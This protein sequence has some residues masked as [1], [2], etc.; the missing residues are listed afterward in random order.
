MSREAVIQILRP[1]RYTFVTYG[2]DVGP[3]Y[4]DYH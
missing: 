3:V 1:A 2:E 4:I